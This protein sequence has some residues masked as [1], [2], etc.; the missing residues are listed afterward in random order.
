MDWAM[1]R[2][3]AYDVKFIRI[4]KSSFFKLKENNVVSLSH[5]HPAA[6]LH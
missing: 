2:T 3:G 5:Y 1:K 4:Q 6:S